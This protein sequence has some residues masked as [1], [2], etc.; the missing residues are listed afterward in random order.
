MKLDIPGDQ[1]YQWKQIPSMNA[2]KRIDHHRFF[3]AMNKLYMIG[4]YIKSSS[5]LSFTSVFHTKT[6]EFE[7]VSKMKHMRAGH[8]INYD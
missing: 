5:F 6:G 4:G 2:V 3:T 8:T 7:K 1:I